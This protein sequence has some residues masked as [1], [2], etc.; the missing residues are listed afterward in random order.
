[1]FI[2]MSWALIYNYHV[3][4]VHA[5]MLVTLHDVCTCVHTLHNVYV[6][7]HVDTFCMVHT[8]L[9]L[10]TTHQR[11]WHK[12]LLCRASHL[13]NVIR[14]FTQQSL[15][16]AHYACGVMY[17]YYALKK[18]DIQNFH[19]MIQQPICVMIWYISRYMLAVRNYCRFIKLSN[20]IW[21]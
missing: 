16:V 19:I 4:Y 1:M 2:C 3:L 14:M 6:H 18:C 5:C 21:L 13:I 8:Y 9:H 12:I 11:N 20:K 15:C 17:V 10:V 7:T